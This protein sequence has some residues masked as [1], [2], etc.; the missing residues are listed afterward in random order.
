MH[1]DGRYGREVKFMKKYKC[2]VCGREMKKKNKCWGYNLCK[3]HMHQYLK[4]GIFLDNNPRTQNDLN[5]YRLLDED[6][7]EFDCY[8]KK[9]NVVGRFIIDK[10]DLE[11]VKYHKWRLDTNN[12]V[13]TG[14]CTESKPRKELSRLLLDVQDKTIVVDHIDG[15]PLNN[16]KNNLRKCSQ[17]ENL[18]NRHF[19]SNNKSG[20]IGVVFDKNRHRW[21]PEIQKEYK[22]V[23]L[24]RY[25]LLEEA[26]YVR[27]IAEI[28]CFGEYQANNNQTFTTI[29][30]DRKI[31]LETYTRNK[32]KKAFGN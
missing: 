3:K 25:T 23:H 1:H 4:Y 19:M 21:A 22:R 29:T 12:R 10:E 2:D 26:K 7:V 17:S 30:K 13:I 20:T 18:C 16:K 5:E 27:Y 31:E 15:N 6:T 8:D 32:L 11:K 28:I 9:Q 14:N 24:G